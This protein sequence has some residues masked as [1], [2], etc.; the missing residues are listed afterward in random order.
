[1]MSLDT[2][3]AGLTHERDPADVLFEGVEVVVQL[4]WNGWRTAMVRFADLG[5]VHWRQP[6]GAPRSLIHGFVRCTDIQSGAIPHDC[7]PKTRP[8]SL[9]VC[10]LRSHVTGD[11][12]KELSRKADRRAAPRPSDDVPA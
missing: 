10:V 5:G 1:M 6:Q 7:N 3:P 11:V 2:A 12:F 8:H 4:E 9:L